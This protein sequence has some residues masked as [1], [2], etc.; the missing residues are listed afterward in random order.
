MIDHP[1]DPANK[2]LRH[3]AMESPE[4]LN[5][6]NGNITTDAQGEAIVALPAYFETLNV[7]FR[8]QLTVID[9]FAQA[10]IGSKIKD[11]RFTIKTDK[12]NV[13]VS[14]Q[15]TGVRNDPY[16]RDHPFQSEPDKRPEERGTYLYPEGYGQPQS[17]NLDHRMS[18]AGAR[19]LRQV[20]LDPS[21]PPTD[22]DPYP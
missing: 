6:Y 18:G 22:P 20:G 2:Y 5:F 17:A 8:Y 10:I 11:N 13:E 9:Q 19:R 7:D 1:L 4:V 15:V 16:V 12:P 3:A 14:W 21:Q